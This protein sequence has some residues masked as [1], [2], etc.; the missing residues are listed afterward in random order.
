M[1]LISLIINE[2]VPLLCFES[3][4]LTPSVFR[5]VAVLG[6][7]PKHGGHSSGFSREISFVTFLLDEAVRL[8]GGPKFV[9]FLGLSVKASRC[10]PLPAPE[11]VIVS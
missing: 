9:I 7:W 11:G 8:I 6:L 2:R 1:Q 10:L 4:V 3:V 5:T